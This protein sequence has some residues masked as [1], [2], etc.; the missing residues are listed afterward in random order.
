MPV[1]AVKAVRS[2]AGNV[3]V[4]WA[5]DESGPP[6]Q[7][8]IQV[9]PDGV[10]WAALGTVDYVAGQTAYAYSHENPIG[11]GVRY[12]V[13]AVNEAGVSAWAESNR[14]PLII[15]PNAPTDVTASI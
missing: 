7:Y 4:S 5:H 10:D 15:V 11:A 3:V 13:R 8:E 2:T 6:I 14:V 12:Q 9:Q 1:F